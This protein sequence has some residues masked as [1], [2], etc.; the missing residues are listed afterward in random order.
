[1]RLPLFYES[2]PYPE[3]KDFRKEKYILSDEELNLHTFKRQ[4]EWL[5]DLVIHE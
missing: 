3:D 5:R 4:F 1:M 2:R